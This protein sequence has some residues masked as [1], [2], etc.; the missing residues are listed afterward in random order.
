MQGCVM[1]VKEEKMTAH[2][3]F[4]LKKFK[5][6]RGFQKPIGTDQD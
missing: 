5:F 3:F 4:V 2:N 1:N 6:D